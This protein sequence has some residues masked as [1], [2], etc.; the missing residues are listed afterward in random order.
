MIVCSCNVLSDHEIRN[1][2][3]AS[4]EQPPS[5]QRVYDCLGCSIRCGR[6]ARAVK[7][8][9]NEAS[10]MAGYREAVFPDAGKVM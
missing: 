8:I 2:V 7:R 6:C 4:R 3:T 10:M 1:V 5:A 9:I